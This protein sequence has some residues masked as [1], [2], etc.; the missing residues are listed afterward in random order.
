MKS[1]IVVTVLLSTLFVLSAVFF[2]ISRGMAMYLMALPAIPAGIYLLNKPKFLYGAIIC[3]PFSNI[4]LPGLPGSLYLFHLLLLF[5]F[6]T[7]VMSKTLL[8]SNDGRLSLAQKAALVYIV[9]ILVI[10]IFRGTG[11]RI[12]GGDQWGGMRYIETL[13][14]FLLLFIKLPFV[15]TQKEWKWLMILFMGFSSL[16]LLSEM[17][18]LVSGGR[19]YHLYYFIKFNMSTFYSYLAEMRG[20][21]V[22]RL[23]T[24]TR[25]ASLFVI[26]SLVT[27]RMKR[28][29]ILFLFTYLTG[30]VLVGVS[31]HRSVL[32]DLIVMSYVIFLISHWSQRWLYLLGSV[33]ALS[34]LL[35]LVYIFASDLPPNFQRTI[36]FLP[37]IS[38]GESARLDAVITIDWRLNLWREGLN[39]IRYNPSYLVLGKGLTYSSSE[40]VALEFFDFSYWWAVLTSNYHQGALSLLIITGIPGLLSIMGFFVFTSLEAILDLKKIRYVGFLSDMYLVLTVY[41]LLL[42]VKYFLIYGNVTT[43]FVPFCYIAFLLRQIKQTLNS[44]D[45]FA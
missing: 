8:K 5:A 31:G 40:F 41:F 44:S 21:D 42:T 11:L 7:S 37:G 22:V 3:L 15:Y 34:V 19:I 30:V 32:I 28:K 24:A 10:M 17:V 29:R 18:F 6:L 9:N 43:A 25:I 23:Q 13:S 1:N 26:F 33:V 2:L 36:S 39:E 35:A 20:S 45:I 12:F 16:P 38:I 27:Y 4:T 14:P